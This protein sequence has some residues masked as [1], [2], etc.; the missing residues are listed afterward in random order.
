MHKK[1]LYTMV[2]GE[3]NW[4]NF[5]LSDKKISS[6]QYYSVLFLSLIGMAAMVTMEM[7]AKLV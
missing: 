3:L 6:K 2:I 5:D 1:K 4:P 7:M